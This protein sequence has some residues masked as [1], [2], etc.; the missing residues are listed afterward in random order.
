MINRPSIMG[1]L[2]DLVKNGVL[3]LRST[4]APTNGTSGS[5]ATIAAP[6]SLLIDTG[7]QNLYINTGTKASPVWKIVTEM[8]VQAGDV[9]IA[10]TGNTDIY[11]FAPDAGTLASV[12][13][14][15][16]AALAANDTNYITFTL[17]NLGQ[18]GAGTAVMLAATA[19]N[20]TKAT[21]GAALVANGK[22]ALT[23]SSTAADLVVAKGDVLLLRA[24]A[25]GTLTGTVTRSTA[26]ARFRNV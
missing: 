11:I 20:T 10:T 25:T 17:T 15:S 24:A 12:D 22:R 16:L 8:Y 21:G 26:I 23:L 9:T 5:G 3:V 2:A 1:M 19:A 6:G 18:A 4:S 13:F 7:S 14:T